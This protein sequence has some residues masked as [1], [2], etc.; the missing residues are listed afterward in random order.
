MPDPAPAPRGRA[1]VTVAGAGAATAVPDTAVLQLGVETRGP[2]PAEALDTCGRALDQILAALDAEGVEPSRRT[3]TGLELHEN[4]E[5]RQPGRGPVAYLAGARLTLRLDRPAQAGQVA[6]AAVVAGGDDARV[7]GL[8]LVVGDPASVAAAARDA[9]WRD[10]LARAEQYA[11]LAGSALG[12]VLEI[13]E[14]PPPPP[15]ARP[16]RLMAAE[17]APTPLSTEPG[18]TTVWSA[19]TVAWALEPLRAAPWRPAG[20]GS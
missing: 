11:A 4:W 2:T 7:H 18:Q 6:A 10:A 15:D 12:P 17:A 14:T 19:V 20:P 8:D 3:T 5:T 16:L 9:A 13:R 1:T